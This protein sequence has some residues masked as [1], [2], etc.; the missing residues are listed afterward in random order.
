[1]ADQEERANKLQDIL[2]SKEELF[3][4]H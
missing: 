4:I 3:Y 2:I 1:L